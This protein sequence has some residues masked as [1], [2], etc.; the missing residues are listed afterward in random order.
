[1]HFGETSSTVLT[2]PLGIG[3]PGGIYRVQ[4]YRRDQPG[5][6]DGDGRS[7]VE[8]LADTAGRLAPLNPADPIL[9]RDGVVAIQD[10][11]MFRDLSYRGP[12]VRI[13]RHLEDLE[14]VK[15]YILEANTDNPRVYFM[16]TETHRAHGSFARAV[17]IPSGFG[18]GFGGGRQPGRRPR[19]G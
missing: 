4:A 14:F 7:D 18:G 13:D 15:F 16:N 12:D 10:R 5:D 9:F 17:G 11:Q 19:T 2:E 1:M 3:S 6:T 8:E